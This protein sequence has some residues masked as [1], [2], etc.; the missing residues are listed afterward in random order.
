M[1][2]P[3]VTIFKNLTI[4]IIAY[5]ERYVYK[6]SPVTKLMLVAFGLM[7]F[8]SF[9]ASY[10]DITQ[11]RVLKENAENVGVILPYFWMMMNCFT[12]AFYATAMRAQIKSVG[13]QDFDTVYYNKCVF[14]L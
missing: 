11:G 5:T 6:G 3:L 10:A 9:I 8:S 1:S 4:I 7:L 12:T 14:M 13:F 2:I